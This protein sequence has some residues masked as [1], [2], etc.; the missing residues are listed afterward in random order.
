MRDVVIIGGGPAGLNAA[1]MLGRVRRDVLLA[2][3]GTPRNAPSEALHGFLTRDGE[4]PAELRAKGRAEIAGYPSVEVVDRTASSAKV[5][6]GG[7]EVSFDDGSTVTARRVMLAMGMRDELP[8]VEGLAPLWGRGVYP[9]P[10]C[11]GW[12]MRD[13]PVAV[14]GGDDKAAHLALNLRR[15]GCE[16][17][18]CS[19]E[20]Q[21]MSDSA[22]QA[23]KV[24]AVE[25]WDGAVASVAATASGVRLSLD[26][27]RTL[28]RRALFVGPVLR[29]AS[30]LAERLGCALHDDG[31]VVV[32]EIAQTSVPGVYAAG[33][34]CRTA[35]G[36]APAGQIVIAAGAGARCAMVMDQELL[37]GDSYR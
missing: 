23:L 19:N 30:D 25:T 3:A 34:L 21:G 32:N 2:D 26:G 29:Q 27:G 5:I 16:V 24:G 37:F 14:L 20:Q 9:C 28:E 31:T 11:H 6:D 33:D 35:A 15:L 36:L 22:R 10:Y 17:V 13:Q 4:N 7:F 8:S 18:L 12:E 1:L